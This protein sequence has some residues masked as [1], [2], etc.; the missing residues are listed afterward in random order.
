M[1]VGGLGPFRSLPAGLPR[2]P[3]VGPLS[4]VDLFPGVAAVAACAVAVLGGRRGFMPTASAL[5]GMQVFWLFFRRTYGSLLRGT[6]GFLP[7]W[8]MRLPVRFTLRPA[9]GASAPGPISAPRCMPR[10]HGF[11]PL[12]PG[13]PPFLGMGRRVLWVGCLRVLDLVV[14]LGG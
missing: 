9:A 10:I 14:P 5:R 13:P 7:C 2:R 3:F 1:F 4:P 11:V 12:V 8:L 6:T